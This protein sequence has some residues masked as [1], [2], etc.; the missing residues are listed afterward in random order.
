MTRKNKL[1][2][3]DNHVQAI[4]KVIIENN[5][6]IPSVVKLFIMRI[7]ETLH[8]TEPKKQLHEYLIH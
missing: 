3:I 6:K 2:K 7:D 4:K 5:L 8:D 1:Q